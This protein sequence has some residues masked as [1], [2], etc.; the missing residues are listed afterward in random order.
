MQP[1][2]L[3]LAAPVLAP[4]F[5]LRAE[6]TL[7]E[8][9]AA[10]AVAER[11]LQRIL[12][13]NGDTEWGRRWGLHRPGARDAFAVMPVTTYDDYIPY[14]GRVAAGEK[15]V[16]TR[17]PVTYLAVTSGTTGPQKRIPVTE[18]QARILVSSLVTPI[19]LAWRAGY[20]GPLRG[21][22]L[23]ILTEQVSGT[24]PGGIPLGAITSGGLRKALWLEQLTCTSPL[25][26]LRVQDQAAARYL[27]L[28]FALGEER[29]WAIISFFPAT[30]LFTLRDL[31]ARAYELLRD[32]ADGTLTRS[33]DLPRQARDEIRSLLR[34]NPE[35]ARALSR[36]YE[37]GRFT[38]RD[39][40]PEVGL[41]FTAGSGPFA[42]YVE[43]L[44]PYL[45]GVPV[46]SPT[47]AASEGAIGI[48][49][50][51]DRPGYVLLPSAAYH[52]FLPLEEADSPD[53]RP[54]PLWQVEPGQAYEVVLTTYAGLTRYRLGDVVRVLGWHGE[55]P[56][57]DFVERRG[58]VLNVVGEKTSEA[59]VTAAFQAACREVGAAVVDYLVT[60]DPE[61]TPARYLLL[62]E[63]LAPGRWADPQVRGADPQAQGADPHP[64]RVDPARLLAAFDAHLQRVAPDY[65]ASV[66][67]G[68]LAPMAARVL[69][70]GA[71][72]RYRARRVAAGAPMDQ[73]KVPHVVPDPEF[74]RRH[75][76]Q[77]IV[78]EVEGQKVSSAG[79]GAN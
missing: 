71:F 59:H 20:L 8:A 29:L 9:T 63:E 33:L 61:H 32:L 49:L 14:I 13:L 47:Y 18:R 65:G 30:L 44:R 53:P 16:L 4:A 56:V 39:I 28:L 11:T 46:F 55:A 37:Q 24:T 40:W 10:R 48:G 7:R 3:Q 67:M 2:L 60:V 74:A 25:P 38:V 70:P 36:L 31:H 12:A 34:P 15:G 35:R 26:V 5:G 54:L 6:R 58:Q 77:E 68:E 43:Q 62:F 78:M 21:R 64:R 79:D 22:V 1:L 50:A 17:E 23:L 76:G 75:F 19:V 27:H 52:E 41:V 66:R 57:V 72:E 42:F 73:V 51:P 45:G 69:R